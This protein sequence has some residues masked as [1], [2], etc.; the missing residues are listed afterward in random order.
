M[1]LH[2]FR[3][4]WST[5][6]FSLLSAFKHSL[7]LIIN[8]RTTTSMLWS[9]SFAGFTGRLLTFSCIRI[10]ILVGMF[11]QTFQILWTNYQKVLKKPKNLTNRYVVE[12]FAFAFRS[13]AIDFSFN[14]IIKEVIFVSVSTKT[15]R[16]RSYNSTIL[17]LS[18]SKVN[19]KSILSRLSNILLK[20]FKFPLAHHFTSICVSDNTKLKR[21]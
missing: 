18:V 9:K 1:F 3:I 8:I 15:L 16:C 4:Y 12:H 13:S 11:A 17:A 14:D 2:P 7:V 20:L 5:R 19:I 10:M 6:S 21:L